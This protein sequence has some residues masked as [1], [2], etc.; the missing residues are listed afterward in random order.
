[1]ENIPAGEANHMARLNVVQRAYVNVGLCSY[2]IIIDNSSHAVAVLS[3]SLDM[4][5]KSFW[6]LTRH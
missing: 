4:T 1:V 5:W 2:A 3:S 6:I